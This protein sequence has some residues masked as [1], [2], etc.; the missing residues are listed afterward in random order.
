MIEQPPYG[1]PLSKT[2]LSIALTL[3]QRENLG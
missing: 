3:T 1:R 2:E